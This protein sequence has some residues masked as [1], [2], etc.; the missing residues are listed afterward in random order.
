MPTE[1]PL[2]EHSYPVTTHVKASTH[3]P[4]RFLKRTLADKVAFALNFAA[5]NVNPDEPCWHF[6]DWK[7]VV[8]AYK[9][10]GVYS[11]KLKAF[12]VDPFPLPKES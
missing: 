12:Y 5:N 10:Y 7:S 9:T 1:I 3:H 6:K 2:K 8:I 4:K 11:E